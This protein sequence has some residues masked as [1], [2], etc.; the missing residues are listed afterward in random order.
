MGTGPVSVRGFDRE[1][2][3]DDLLRPAPAGGIGGRRGVVVGHADQLPEHVGVAQGVGELRVGVIGR[4]R[5]V[6]G[7]APE[8]R[9]IPAVFI[10][11]RPRR[12]W[13]V[14]RETMLVEALCN[15]CSLP[16]T[17]KPVSSKCARSAPAMRAA[18][19]PVNAPRSF[20]AAA[21]AVDT[22]P[23]E[24]GVENNSPSPSGTATG[25]GPCTG[26]P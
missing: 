25:T 5:I 19:W 15:Q 7:D 10:A 13:Q 12:R 23:S 17:R 21:V 20:P 9:R 1:Q 18:T 11:S 26:T 8:V 22:V 6:H 14:I 24:T 2:C 16:S 4:P 3:V